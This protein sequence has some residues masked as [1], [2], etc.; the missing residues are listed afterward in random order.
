MFQPEAERS[1]FRKQNGSFEPSPFHVRL[2]SRTTHG[3]TS[4]EGAD[5]R[6]GLFK[7]SKQL[8]IHLEWRRGAVVRRM[9]HE[10]EWTGCVTFPLPPLDHHQPLFLMM[11]FDPSTGRP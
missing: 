3:T 10:G 11:F 7:K 6:R 1:C 2:S 4:C 8:S 5:R 9:E